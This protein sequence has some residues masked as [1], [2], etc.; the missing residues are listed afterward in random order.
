MEPSSGKPFTAGAAVLLVLVH[1]ASFFGVLLL[2]SVL[3]GDTETVALPFR[4]AAVLVAPL[5]ALYVGLVRHA[6][7]E[8]TL[9]ALRL[10]RP[11]TGSWPSLV[12][13]GVAGAALAPLVALLYSWLFTLLPPERDPE[14]LTTATVAL[15]VPAQLLSAAFQEALF[16]GLVQPRLV[17]LFGF[18]RGVW[19]AVLIFVLAQISAL[20]I[21][22]AAVTG[23]VA[24]LVAAWSGTTWAA[25]AASVAL[26]GCL[27]VLPDAAPPLWSAG[28]G[29][30]LAALALREIHKRAM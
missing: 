24:A 10:G 4:V 1:L 28:A 22:V 6:P 27:I 2:G 3:S 7:E 17:E 13:A 5:V 30:L 8:A 26:Q 16:R 29:A 11:V 20:S 23:I 18:R 12:L 25:V 19:S 21:P 9:A 14:V 15:L